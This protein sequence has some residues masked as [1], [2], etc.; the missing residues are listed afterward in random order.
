MLLS[1]LFSNPFIFVAIAGAL[2]IAIT[3]H[4]FAHAYM[5]E[6]LGDPTPRI[7]KRLTLNPLA[8]LDPLGT[9]MILIVGFGWGKPVQFDPYNLENPK[10]DAAFISLAG[11]VTNIILAIA[12]SLVLRLAYSAVIPG[13]VLLNGIL[14]PV[15]YLN[16]V[17]ALFNL[18]PIHPLDGG[19]ILV[20][21]LP[22]KDAIEVDSFLRRYGIFILLLMLLPI[23]GGVAPVSYFLSPVI[24]FILKI[25]IPIPLVI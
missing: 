4:E 24:N 2:L 10:K 18:I 16:I 15:I 9:L 19:K 22:D 12:L 6:R 23:Y 7:Q 1:L 11:P 20:G 5:A 14:Q 25:L 17:L 21:L 3:V 13:S 8:H